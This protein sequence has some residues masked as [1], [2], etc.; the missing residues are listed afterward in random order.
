[1]FL[2]GL[3]ESLI[4]TGD[5]E[6]VIPGLHQPGVSI[7]AMTSQLGFSTYMTT[8]IQRQR[9]W[10]GTAMVIVPCALLLLAIMPALTE[11]NGSG[12]I[13]GYVSFHGRPLA[14]G[15]ISF[16][17]IDPHDGNWGDGLIDENGHFLIRS[18]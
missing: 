6:P 17:P 3:S 10:F 18:G 7:A 1:L 14:G 11:E 5:D 9:F 2:P 12:Q 13:E 15:F 16:I 8:S 4:K